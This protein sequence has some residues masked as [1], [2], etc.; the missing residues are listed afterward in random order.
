MILIVS[1]GSNKFNCFS[2]GHTIVPRAQIR[3]LVVILLMRITKLVFMLA[4]ISVVSM[5]KSCQ[6]R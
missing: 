5:G 6:G 2:R 3:L 1:V 4:S